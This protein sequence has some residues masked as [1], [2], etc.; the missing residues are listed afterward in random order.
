MDANRHGLAVGDVLP[1]SLKLFDV[2]NRRLALAQRNLPGFAACAVSGR[3]LY[4]HAHLQGHPK[5]KRRNVSAGFNSG[6]HRYGHDPRQRLAATQV[7]ARLRS[8]ASGCCERSRPSQAAMR[9]LSPTCTIAG[10]RQRL[11]T[12]AIVS[13]SL[14]CG[15]RHGAIQASEEA[16]RAEVV[17]GNR[18]GIGAGTTLVWRQEMLLKTAPVAQLRGGGYRCRT[19]T[20]AAIG[21]CRSA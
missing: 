18:R 3:G 11:E 21:S 9:W 8:W 12:R 10:C 13:A 4:A 2:A 7:A 17:T 15:V 16:P 5:P 19:L 20:S 1:A 14:S 6:R